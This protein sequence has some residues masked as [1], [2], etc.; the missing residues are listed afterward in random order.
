MHS[1]CAACTWRQSFCS[2][3]D[4]WYYIRFPREHTLIAGYWALQ[5][6]RYLHS[7]EVIQFQRLVIWYLLHSSTVNRKVYSVQK[8]GSAGTFPVA[9]HSAL[10]TR[11][12]GRGIDG[13]MKASL[14]LLELYPSTVSLFWKE[15]WLPYYA[16]TDKL[17][18]NTINSQW[19]L[20][21]AI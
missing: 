3:A 12:E 1:L 2:G 17:E 14:F 19:D 6:L 21:L 13:K 7:A 15:R 18:N 4:P 5:S 16:L 11:P 9:W 20:K 10:N 8:M